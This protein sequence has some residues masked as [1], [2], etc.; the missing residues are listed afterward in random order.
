VHFTPVGADGETLDLRPGDMVE[1]EI[2][3]AAPH[4]LVA[5][6]PVLSVRRT[7]AGDVWDARTA[8]P[9]TAVSL[10][11]PNIGVPVAVPDGPGCR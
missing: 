1:I 11:L 10:G 7:K 4:H 3:R 9:A 8:E 5:D 2:T 6:S